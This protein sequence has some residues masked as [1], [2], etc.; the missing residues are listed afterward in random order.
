[1]PAKQRGFTL[2]ELLIVV[3]IIG[4]LAAIAVPAYQGAILRSKIAKVQTTLRVMAQSL[5]QYRIDRGALPL[6]S[7]K[8]IQNS[9]LT[10]PIAYLADRPVDDFAD[11]LAG[12]SRSGWADYGSQYTKGAPHYHVFPRSRTF[13]KGRLGPGFLTS[14]YFQM[15]S[16]GGWIIYTQGPD[17]SWTDAV[18]EISNGLTSR[19]DI[20]KVGGGGIKSGR[21]G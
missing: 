13:L 17:K 20:I 12:A 10:T 1:M 2:I 5:E 7:D 9:W 3:A 6:H 18:Y 21:I 4:I 16:G 8:G 15:G 14:P 11:F 19:G